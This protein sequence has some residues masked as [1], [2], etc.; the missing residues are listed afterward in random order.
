MS[1]KIPVQVT[2]SLLHIT[3]KL[4]NPC[5]LHESP[6]IVFPVQVTCSFLH[7]SGKIP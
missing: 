5:Y 4:K 2:C 3:L 7:I 1:R 6:Y